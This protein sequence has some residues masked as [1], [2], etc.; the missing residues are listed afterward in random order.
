MLSRHYMAISND[1]DSSGPSR[2]PQISSPAQRANHHYTVKWWQMERGGRCPRNDFGG[3]QTRGL[4]APLPLVTEIS[5]A[6]LE[7]VM[8]AVVERVAVARLI[9]G[10]SGKRVGKGKRGAR[11]WTRMDVRGKK[12]NKGWEVKEAK[13]GER[14][15]GGMGANNKKV[16]RRTRTS[17]LR[18]HPKSSTHLC[19]LAL[20]LEAA[21]GLELEVGV[22]AGTASQEKKVG[23]TGYPT[24]SP[25]RVG[26]GGDAGEGARRER[27]TG[28]S[29]GAG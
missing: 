21:L 7:D 5:A 19:D 3:S 22:G 15:I 20:E 27:G 8:G 13:G 29:A 16:G 17:I 12:L 26:D 23:R 10:M 14:T 25:G 6:P 18:L 9:K 2:Q 4:L 11:R 24:R 28:D 1:K